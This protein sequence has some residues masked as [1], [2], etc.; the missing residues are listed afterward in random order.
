MMG[1]LEKYPKS[2]ILLF[3]SICMLP[4]F[5]FGVGGF[6]AAIHGLWTEVFF[7]SFSNGEIR[8]THTPEFYGGYGSYVFLFY[9]PLSF[10]LN[11]IFY[12]IFSNPENMNFTVISA[13]A[14]LATF[15]S[16]LTCYAMLRANFKTLPSLLG[17]ILYIVIPQHLALYYLNAAPPQYW[18]FVFFPI[19]ILGI[20]KLAKNQKNGLSLL[21]LGQVLLILTNIPYVI[22]FLPFAYLYGALISSNLKMLGKLF[23]AAIT[24]FAIC[25]F[26]LLPMYFLKDYVNIGAHWDEQYGFDYRKYFLSM[27]NINL[28]SDDILVQTHSYLQI[29]RILILCTLIYFLAF[30]LDA[31]KEKKG[32]ICFV[33]IALTIF[34]Q[35]EFSDFIWQIFPIIQIVQFPA[36]FAAASTIFAIIIAVMNL[37]KTKNYAKLSLILIPFLAFTYIYAH[38][39][40]AEKISDNLQY[41]HENK[42]EYYPHYIPKDVKDYSSFHDAQDFKT[43]QKDRVTIVSGSADIEVIEE[44]ARNLELNITAKK[45][46][47]ININWFYIPGWQAQIGSE[48]LDVQESDY[49]KTMKIKILRDLDDEILRVYLPL[50]IYEKL[51]YLI[52][53]LTL[54]LIAVW[55]AIK[56]QSNMMERD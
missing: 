11:S 34:L 31:V 51:G 8:P 4:L 30:F 32:K 35:L 56:S 13:S 25:A 55:Y 53:A 54:L 9:P 37:E 10:Y 22:V 2:I 16:G 1:F 41:L 50:Y 46:A 49:M 48:S 18:C 24:S 29:L 21:C 12:P 40:G 20:E 3:S 19:I 17:A 36:R 6:D 15:L 42:I 43:W 39:R 5:I 47:E 14:F 52:S 26:Y 44:E 23:L 27:S 38:T 45:G 28:P 33:L 7:N